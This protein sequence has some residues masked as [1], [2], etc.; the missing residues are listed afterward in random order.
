VW[1][2]EPI[3]RMRLLATLADAT[4]GLSGGALAGAIYAHVHAHGDPFVRSYTSRVLQAACV[5]LF[6]MI[7]RCDISIPCSLLLLVCL[8]TVL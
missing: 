2:A 7:R 4:E 5:P 8:M 1:L 6:E 3:R